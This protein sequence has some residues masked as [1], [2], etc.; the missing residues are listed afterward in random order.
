MEIIQ[1]P[2][3]FKIVFD[4][5]PH[6]VEQVRQLPERRWNATDKS[7]TVPLQYRREVE[8]FAHS[9]RFTWKSTNVVEQTDFTIPDLPELKLDIPLKMTLREYQRGGVAYNLL[10]KKVIIG[11]DMGLGKTGQAIASIIGADILYQQTG[12]LPVFPCLVICPSSVKLNWVNQWQ[13]WTGRNFAMILTDATKKN[14]QLY[15]N[16]GMAKVFITNYESLKKYFVKSIDKGESKHLRLNHI[17]FDERILLFNSVILDEFH[18]V[19]DSKTMQSKFCKG[20]TYKKNYIF[21]LTGTPVINKPKDLISQLSIIEQMHVFGGYQ[22]FTDR[23]CNGVNEASNL[24][25]LNYNLN[26]YCFYR[27]SKQE[28]AKELPP[29]TRQIVQC[30]ISNRKEYQTAEYDLVN[31]LKQYKEA[32]DEK[33]ATALRGEIMVKIGILKNISARGKMNSVIDFIDDTI[34]QN[35]KLVLFVHLK[36][37]AHAFKSHYPHAATITGDDNIQQRQDSIRRFRENDNCMLIICSIKA[38]GLG[39]DG[40]QFASSTVAFIELP[41]HAADCDQAEDRLNR[42][43]QTKSVSCIYFLGAK[44]ID[45]DIY[46]IIERKREIS[47]KV[48]GNT[49]EVKVDFVSEF[50][51]LFNKQ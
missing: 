12:E 4:Y 7:W 9:N 43:G 20:I 31:Y 10:H 21:G 41:W 42:I 15:F 50:A 1:Q 2:Y 25:E 22:R 6:L 49:D 18:K 14:W 27:R 19:K 17:K 30:E 11:D 13:M 46:K 34:E 45:E 8:R 35:E 3:G 38:A 26:K 51:N 36:E 33:I 47:D 29:K 23:Y 44:T 39:I 24:K 32:S 16:S 48:T 37:V 40:L 28:V 5:R